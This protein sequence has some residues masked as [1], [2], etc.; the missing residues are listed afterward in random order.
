M[1]LKCDIGVN[2]D[3][4]DD[5]DDDQGDGDGDCGDGQQLPW[6]SNLQTTCRLGVVML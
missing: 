4:D 5:G 1:H 6:A 3:D 2:V